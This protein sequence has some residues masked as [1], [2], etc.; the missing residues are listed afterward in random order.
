MLEHGG[1]L[2]SAARRYRIPLEQWL[3]LST[4]VNPTAWQ[5]NNV[6]RSNWARLPEDDDGLI[7]A[8]QAYYG[9]ANV[10]PIAGSQ[11]AIM[12]LPRM[13]PPGR[14]GVL[15]P[16]YAEHA[17]RWLEAGH[18]VVPL[19]IDECAAGADSL[20]VLVVVNPNNP[21]GHRFRRA[22]LLDWHARLAARGGWLLIDEAF[23]DADSVESLATWSDR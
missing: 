3:D 17:A 5:G 7:E 12:N 15:T 4:G 10:L 13:R 9:A 16:S 8:A 11:A 14:V 22:D 1:R 23:A 21:T 2:R 6:P 19:T 18:E 20:D